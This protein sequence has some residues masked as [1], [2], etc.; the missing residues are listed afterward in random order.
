M[1]TSVTVIALRKFGDWIV[2]KVVVEA[3]ELPLVR[4]GELVGLEAGPEGEDQRVQHDGHG[5]DQRRRQEEIPGKGPR[6]QQPAQ[7]RILHRGQV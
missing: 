1:N 7:D 2:Q 4:P 5:D 6:P 3:D